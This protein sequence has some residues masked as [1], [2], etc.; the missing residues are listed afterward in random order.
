M[1]A[2]TTDQ[3]G[4]TLHWTPARDN[5]VDWDEVGR[6]TKWPNRLVKVD[7][8][9][10]DVHR[11]RRALRDGPVRQVPHARSD[12]RVESSATGERHQQRRLQGPRRPLRRDPRQQQRHAEA[13]V[14]VILAGKSFT[15]DGSRQLLRHLPLAGRRP[16]RH[17]ATT[18]PYYGPSPMW[19]PT[20]TPPSQVQLTATD[21]DRD[22]L[23]YYAT[24]L[25]DGVSLD[26]RTGR[27]DAAP[28]DRR[29]AR[30]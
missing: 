28:D 8:T 5:N 21:R 6:T 4:G 17:T 25:P 14:R 1:W 9:A 27:G 22:K 3:D 18:R 16:V 13:T 2:Q 11:P 26:A 12:V 19:S 24:D 15:V 10:K 7:T 30:T 23:A 20:S 29:Q